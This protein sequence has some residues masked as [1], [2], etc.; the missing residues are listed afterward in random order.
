LFRSAFSERWGCSVTNRPVTP[1]DLACSIY[2][3]LGIDPD[4]ELP[5][6]TGRKSQIVRNG[7]SVCELT[8]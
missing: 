7:Q 6:I 4:K 2:L 5:S 1:E 3:L 8:A